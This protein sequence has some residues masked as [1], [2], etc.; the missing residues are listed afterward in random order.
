MP[1]RQSAVLGCI[2]MARHD[3]M[4]S[5]CTVFDYESELD[6]SSLLCNLVTWLASCRHCNSSSASPVIIL[7]VFYLLTF[8]SSPFTFLRL[9][10]WYVLCL[11]FR[12]LHLF[13]DHPF[14][15]AVSTK[16]QNHFHT[17]NQQVPVRS[18]GMR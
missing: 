17:P 15:A 16:I 2:Y 14:S 5:S 10:H 12:L 4:V 18:T 8:M 3:G 6:Q 9:E 7:A 11:Q 13:G 1:R